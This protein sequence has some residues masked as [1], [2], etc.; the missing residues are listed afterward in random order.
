[1]LCHLLLTYPMAN[2]TTVSGQGG[3]NVFGDM[4]IRLKYSQNENDDW[5]KVE[6]KAIRKKIQNR[7]AKR[8]SRTSD[9]MSSQKS[10]LTLHQ[11]RKDQ[12]K[13]RREEMNGRLSL[14]TQTTTMM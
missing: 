1:M 4:Q 3:A 8:K 14:G 2:V 13:R 10:A 12:R 5:T 6:D 9:H 11:E 7:L